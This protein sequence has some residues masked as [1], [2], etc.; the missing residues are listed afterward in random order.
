MCD[1]VDQQNAS[2]QGIH[3]FSEIDGKTFTGEDNRSQTVF[4]MVMLEWDVYISAIDG[5]FSTTTEEVIK[6][7]SKYPA[8]AVKKFEI[9]IIELLDPGSLPTSRMMYYL[10]TMWCDPLVGW[11]NWTVTHLHMPLCTSFKFLEDACNLKIRDND[12]DVSK[13]I[14]CMATRATMS[15]SIFL[16]LKWQQIPGI[17]AYLYIQ[18]SGLHG[19][20]VSS[21]SARKQWF[22][23]LLVMH[24]MN[25]EFCGGLDPT[26]S[27]NRTVIDNSICK[28]ICKQ[29]SVR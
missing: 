15:P 10:I 11:S 21:N 26:H 20:A 4:A 1:E 16:T 3:V 19:M 23:T 9:W 8:L 7:V 2:I 27:H 25:L 18:H 28:K 6:Y 24:S 13:L 12:F 22:V 17:F 29:L 14:R 5:A